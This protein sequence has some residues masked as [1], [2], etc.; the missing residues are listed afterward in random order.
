MTEKFIGSEQMIPFNGEY[1][2]RILNMKPQLRELLGE[3]AESLLEG[4]ILGIKDEYVAIAAK[5]LQGEGVDISNLVTAFLQHFSLEEDKREL[6]ETFIQ[7]SLVTTYQSA[8]MLEAF[9][10]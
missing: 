1:L 10:H 6:G 9:N 8:Q 4:F 5:L 3:N 7:S 2:L